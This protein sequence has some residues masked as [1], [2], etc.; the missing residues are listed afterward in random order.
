[1]AS[2]PLARDASKLGF[3]DADLFAVDGPID[4]H[5]SP[6]V[7]HFGRTLFSRS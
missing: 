6:H 7:L 1:M 4:R 5:S 3:G 2:A